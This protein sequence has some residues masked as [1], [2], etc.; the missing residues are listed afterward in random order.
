MEDSH[1]LCA[2][3]LESEYFQGLKVT[4]LSDYQPEE[5]YTPIYF[6]EILVKKEIFAFWGFVHR[7]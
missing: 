4:I 1:F 7:K 3:P 5:S 6:I 2:Y